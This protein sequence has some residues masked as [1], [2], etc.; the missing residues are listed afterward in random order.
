MPIGEKYE[1]ER[2][3]TWLCISRPASIKEPNRTNA[4]EGIDGDKINIEQ[5][6][7]SLIGK[8]KQRS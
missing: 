1:D 8:R 7:A 2:E 3:R 4:V 6:G 5:N